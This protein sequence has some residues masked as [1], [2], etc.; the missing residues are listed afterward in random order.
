MLRRHC[1]LYLQCASTSNVQSQRSIERC[2]NVHRHYAASRRTQ[3]L[4]TESAPFQMPFKI[5]TH[6]SQKKLTTNVSVGKVTSFKNSHV[7]AKNLNF[8]H[9]KVQ[10]P[11]VCIR[12]PYWAVQLQFHT[13]V[14]SKLDITLW[15]VSHPVRFTNVQTAP[16]IYRRSRLQSGAN[17]DALVKKNTSVLSKAL[18]HRQTQIRL[19]L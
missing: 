1:C 16:D 10:Y 14:S 9:F 17:M 19:N 12:T 11:C 2:N 7:D 5:S 15:S 3:S 8:I 4:H 13:F 6:N 18:L